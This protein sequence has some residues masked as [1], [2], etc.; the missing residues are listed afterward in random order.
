MKHG[1]FP[2]LSEPN[3]G[4]FLSGPLHFKHN[5]PGSTT[6]L[7]L[8]HVQQHQQEQAQIWGSHKSWEQGF[9]NLESKSHSKWFW[10]VSEASFMTD[11]N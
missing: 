5:F 1:F 11:Q 9:Q 4:S 10:P 7:E 3:L 2:L 8:N 6:L